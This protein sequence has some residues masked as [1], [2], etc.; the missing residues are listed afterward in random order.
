MF[1]G[2]QLPSSLPPPRSP[3][4]FLPTSYSIF[5]LFF[6]NHFKC[7]LSLETVQKPHH[8]PINPHHPTVFRGG[9][10]AHVT[11]GEWGGAMVFPRRGQC[12]SHCP[13]HHN[14]F[15]QVTFTSQL[16]RTS[17]QCLGKKVKATSPQEAGIPTR[18][19]N[20]NFGL[21]SDGAY[22]PRWESVLVKYTWLIL[23]GTTHW[24]LLTESRKRNW[25]TQRIVSWDT[26][27]PTLVIKL[28][29]PSG[30]P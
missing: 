7:C 28:Q 27:G 6:L 11:P 15:W 1:K 25:Q 10:I 19:R 16:A 13:Q 2:A 4:L 3:S 9:D 8:F 17:S 20:P 30:S 5:F 18:S 22:Q 21:I 24:E 29:I 12:M 23:E 14:D 26:N